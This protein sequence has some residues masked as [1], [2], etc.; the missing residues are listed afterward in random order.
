M[1]IYQ[2]RALIAQLKK[3]DDSSNNELI[4][5]YKRKEKEM[6]VLIQDKINVGLKGG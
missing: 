1:N 3:E 5:F 6:L 4:A 2:L